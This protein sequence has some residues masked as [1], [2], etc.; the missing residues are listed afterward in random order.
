MLMCMYSI[1]PLPNAD[2]FFIVADNFKR[3]IYQV[4][5]TTGT[6]SQLLPFSLT[7][8]P[9]ALAYD[10]TNKLLYWTELLTHTINK[11]SLNTNS[12]TIIYRDP[13]SRGKEL[14]V[15]YLQCIFLPRHDRRRHLAIDQLAVNSR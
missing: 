4:D 9:I 3:N 7:T 10:S 13:T 12:S 15:N 5:S 2:N 1:G 8:N 11:Y 14:Y 6:T